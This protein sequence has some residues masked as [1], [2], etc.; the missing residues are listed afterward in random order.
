MRRRTRSH[1]GN[2]IAASVRGGIPLPAGLLEM[3]MKPYRWNRL[4]TYNAERAR[5]IVHT[6]EYQREMAEE[7]R[8]FDAE[9]VL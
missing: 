2:L 1:I 9:K 8:L 7:Q 3:E 6:E 4:A 5:G